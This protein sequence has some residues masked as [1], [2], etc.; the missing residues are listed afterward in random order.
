MLRWWCGAGFP[1]RWRGGVPPGSELRRAEGN[2]GAT[3]REPRREYTLRT[4]ESPPGICSSVPP[5]S[6]GR[7]RGAMPTS[8]LVTLSVSAPDADP[9]RPLPAPAPTHRLQVIVLNNRGERKTRERLREPN[10]NSQ[11]FQPCGALTPISSLIDLLT[12]SKIS[13]PPSWPSPI[14]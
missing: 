8:P 14:Q 4:R 11:P 9:P 6:P 2:L 5:P 1:G 7:S 10:S 12:V 3:R 13:S